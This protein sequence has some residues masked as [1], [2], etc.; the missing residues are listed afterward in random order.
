[1]K[2]APL[3]IKALAEYLSG[4]VV[5]RSSIGLA[6]PPGR[7]DRANESAKEFFALREAF[8]VRGYANAEEAERAI[9]RSLNGAAK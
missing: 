9:R 2:D 7:I 6:L 5:A 8:G 4:P 3:G 1:M